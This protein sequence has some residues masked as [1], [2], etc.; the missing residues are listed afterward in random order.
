MTINKEAYVN[1]ITSQYQNSPKF[2]A[3]LRGLVTS[4][5]AWFSGSLD[6]IDNTGN[7]KG[8]FGVA[9]DISSLLE[10]MDNNFDLDVAIGPQL[11]VVGQLVGLGRQLTVPVLKTD[12][13]FTWDDVNLGWDVGLW[14]DD[15][16]GGSDTEVL[17]LPD[18]IYRI[19]LKVKIISNMWDGSPAY[20]YQMWYNLIGDSILLI[21]QNNLN[22]TSGFYMFGG[23]ELAIFQSLFDGGYISFSPAGIK[24]TYH[25]NSGLGLGLTWLYHRGTPES[26]WE[27]IGP[28]FYLRWMSTLSLAGAGTVYTDNGGYLYFR[29]ALETGS[30]YK[31]GRIALV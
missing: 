10:S 30:Y 16:G 24:T 5:S 31:I 20:L 7:R 6:P 21:L 23:P 29:G 11:D 17:N 4:D 14:T 19:A 3:W 26:Y 18:D 27:Q 12:F 9:Q 1:L 28:N 25:V 22:M 13:G 8:L 15:I 2:L